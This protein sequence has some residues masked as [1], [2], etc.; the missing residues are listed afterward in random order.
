M[1]S[2]ARRAAPAIAALAVLGAAIPA[3]ACADTLETPALRATDLA[4]SG[5]WQAWGAPT[6]DGRWRLA[7]RAPD[8]TVTLPDIP[9]FG[10]SPNP[11]IGS[12]RFAIGGRRLLA[13]YSRCEGASAIAGCDVYAYDLRNGGEERVA[14]ISTSAASEYGP[15]LAIGRWV[16]VRPARASR[17]RA[18]TPSTS[19]PAARA[20]RGASAR[21]SPARPSR[22][23]AAWPT[24]TA[25][26]AATA[27]P[28]AGCPAA[29]H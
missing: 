27:S 6:P 18:S 20:R 23:P 17:A 21:R 22:T 26:A 14:A 9:D 25:R 24:P 12:D 8:G 28:S 13:V 7:V 11:S 4:A 5:G 16:F 3:A 10:F 29:R 1:P 2:I 15:A 19:I